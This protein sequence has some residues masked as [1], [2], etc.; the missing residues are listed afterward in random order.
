MP[1]QVEPRPD[2]LAAS[3]LS[4]YIQAR[5]ARK[6]NV[7]AHVTFVIWIFE[8]IGYVICH[9]L[10]SFTSYQYIFSLFWYHLL[11]PNFFLMNTSHNKDR[12]IDDGFVNTI[13]N[14]LRIPINL[15][16][17]SCLQSNVVKNIKG[18]NG[19]FSGTVV[20]A[21]KSNKRTSCPID[22]TESATLPNSV[23]VHPASNSKS[24][25]LNTI[26]D[27][28]P[29]TSWGMFENVDLRRQTICSYNLE[30]IS[31]EKDDEIY[32]EN[33]FPL[34]I[35]ERL[36]RQMR[37]YTSN[38]NI[39]LHYFL[40]LLE[41]EEQM[42]DASNFHNNFKVVNF[43]END[44]DNSTPLNTKSAI[45]ITKR[46]EMRRNIL[47]KVSEYSNNSDTYTK[48]FEELIDQEENFIANN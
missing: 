27:K 39:Y 19:D 46:I 32:I 47:E 5:N 30:L 28:I 26:S 12:I 4:S 34:S 11:L 7:N 35:R 43:I 29:S 14:G 10:F 17:A 33:R 45:D 6:A 21:P 23:P 16:I 3:T 31:D 38:E 20:I 2:N 48:Y 8:C 1:R 15:N 44:L 41:Y 42:K 22:D 9:I 40:Q 13:R 18:N 36:F 24:K 37:K 25:P